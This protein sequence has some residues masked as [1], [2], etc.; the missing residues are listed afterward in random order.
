MG[1]DKDLQ[2][3]VDQQDQENDEYGFCFIAH[4]VFQAK[5]QTI[6]VQLFTANRKSRSIN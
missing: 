6:P 2:D 5:G 3:L 4:G 1:F